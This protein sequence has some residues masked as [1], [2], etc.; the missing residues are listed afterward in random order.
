MEISMGGG[1][2]LGLKGEKIKKGGPRAA[3]KR[4]ALQK[5]SLACAENAFVSL[6]HPLSFPVASAAAAVSS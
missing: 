1:T 6:S 2:P 3:E 4:V 5:P